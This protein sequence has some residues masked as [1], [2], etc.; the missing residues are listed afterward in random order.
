M[1]RPDGKAYCATVLLCCCAR[2]TPPLSSPSKT[3]F[4]PKRGAPNGEHKKEEKTGIIPAAETSQITPAAIRGHAVLQ[5]SAWLIL[6]YPL[7]LYCSCVWSYRRSCPG[8]LL[9]GVIPGLGLT[10]INPRFMPFFYS[11][12]ASPRQMIC[13]TQ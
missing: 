7:R 3:W 10:S 2:I 5:D 4:H 11:G 9:L 1:L 12:G 6:P 13:A 8:S